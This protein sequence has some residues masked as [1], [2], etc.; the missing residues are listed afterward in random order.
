MSANSIMAK[1]ATT[2]ALAQ[3]LLLTE[4]SNAS[5]LWPL[6]EPKTVVTEKKDVGKVTFTYWTF[7]NSEFKIPRAFIKGKF[8]V[9]DYRK[10][11]WDDK[12]MEALRVCMHFGNKYDY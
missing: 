8:E 10:A 5:E 1:V 11:P 3:L 9:E 7:V 4:G 12:N 6:S 2:A